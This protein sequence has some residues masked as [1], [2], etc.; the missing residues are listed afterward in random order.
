MIEN[1]ILY[2]ALPKNKFRTFGLP[3][4]TN[5]MGFREKNFKAKKPKD[6]FRILVF[7]DSVT[8]GRALA[9][10]QRYTFILEKLLNIHLAKINYIKK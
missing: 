2:T 3:Y 9:T 5:W 6:V 10:Q 7:G 4:D 1:S 8:F